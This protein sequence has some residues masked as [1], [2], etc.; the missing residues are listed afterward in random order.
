M[1]KFVSAQMVVLVIVWHLALLMVWAEQPPTPFFGITVHFGQT[2]DMRPDYINYCDTILELVSSAGIHS[3]RDE[4][5]WYIVEQTPGVYSFPPEY[6]QYI[7]TALAKNIQVILALD[8][9]NPLYSGSPDLALAPATEEQRAAFCRYCQ[10]VVSHYAPWGVRYYEIWNEP[11]LPGFWHPEPNAMDYAELLKA[12]YQACKAVDSTVF[13]MGCATSMVDLSFIGQ[14]IAAGGLEYMDAVSV[15]PYQPVMA[16]EIKLVAEMEKVYQ[17]SAPKPVWITEMGYPTQG[18]SNVSETE[19]AN[20]LARSYLLLSALP[21]LQHVNWYEFHNPC[22]D[23]GNQECHFKVVRSDFKP[24]PSYLAY[25]SLCHKL[26]GLDCIDAQSES[27][28]YCYKYA[29]QND[30]VLVLW[31]PEGVVADSLRLG[32]RCAEITDLSGEKTEYTYRQDG[33][34]ELDIGPTPIFVSYR[35]NL[36]SL[37]NLIISPI[38]DSMAMV[39]GDIY[40]WEAIAITDSG[41]SA[42]IDAREAEWS[43]SHPVLRVAAPGQMEALMEGTGEITVRFGTLIA[44]RIIQILP[45]TSSLTVEPF[46]FLPDYRKDS[47]N[48]I[49]CHLHLCDTL[50]A[51]P[52]SALALDYAFYYKRIDQHRLMLDCDYAL[53]GT[54]DTLA[55]DLYNNGQSHF[56]EYCFKD[57]F[58][59]QTTIRTQRAS[60]ECGWETLSAPLDVVDS[61]LKKPYRLVSITLFLIQTSAKKDTLYQGTILLD[62]IRLQTGD[63]QSFLEFDDQPGESRFQVWHYP[64]PAN[65]SV[66]FRIVLPQPARVSLFLYSMLGEK[67]GTILDDCVISANYTWNYQFPSLLSSGIYFYS[68]CID[69]YQASRRLIH[70]K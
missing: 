9:S 30:T 17:L 58:D 24:K 6:D 33:V 41:D 4:V 62:E 3:I 67:I 12:A 36:P 49:T 37:T 8:Y 32:W 54:F 59:C 65:Q 28:V 66:T 5:Y 42:R 68:L 43:A 10:A 20:F 38:L 1:R 46:T 45:K 7:Q 31:N 69:Q 51:N 11:N 16:P 2:F 47:L 40:Q 35:E 52:P 57:Y 50:Y 27:G 64:N 22:N 39:V 13:V 19:Q 26:S 60:L 55:I 34:F 29:L 14:V 18:N 61:L 48:L 15:H 25:R 56:F 44:S 70:L 21:Y 53:W 23:P 63:A